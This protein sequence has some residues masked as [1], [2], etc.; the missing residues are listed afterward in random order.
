MPSMQEK[1]KAAL[2]KEAFKK[3]LL[4]TNPPSH[5]AL[6]DLMAPL[7]KKFEPMS[8]EEIHKM[9]SACPTEDP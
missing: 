1:M 5:Q 7:N 4:P 2:G 6:V 3:V 9:V 8:P